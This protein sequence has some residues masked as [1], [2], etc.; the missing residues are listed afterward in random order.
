[1]PLVLESCDR[2]LQQTLQ[3]FDD[4]LSD[5]G[6]TTRAAKS[7]G[8]EHGNHAAM[9]TSIEI[10]AMLHEIRRKCSS[11]TSQPDTMLLI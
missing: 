6:Q 1:M 4:L 10:V 7:S 5:N 11:Q 8:F 3:R 9:S 2:V